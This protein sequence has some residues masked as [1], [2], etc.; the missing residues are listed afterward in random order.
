LQLSVLYFAQ[1]SQALRLL[2]I[3]KT[4]VNKYTE[5]FERK[6]VNKEKKIFT[7]LS[8]KKPSLAIAQN[9]CY[10]PFFYS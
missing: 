2:R 9:L 4:G 3:S 7:K 6:N 1:R 5:N 10:K 8:K